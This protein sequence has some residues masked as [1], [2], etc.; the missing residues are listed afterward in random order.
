[1]GAAG[2]QGE[3]VRQASAPGGRIAAEP[4]PERLRILLE[5]LDLQAGIEHRG[6]DLP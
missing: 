5:A 3:R 6:D 2:Q 1:M 4:A